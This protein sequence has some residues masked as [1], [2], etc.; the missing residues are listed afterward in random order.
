MLFLVL[1]VKDVCNLFLAQQLN[2]LTARELQPKSFSDQRRAIERFAK[3][4]RIN[5]VVADPA[6]APA[7][8]AR[9][10]EFDDF[11]FAV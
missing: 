7:V 10:F 3:K 11:R 2:R 8:C 1:L 4:D 5:R 9:T 6:G